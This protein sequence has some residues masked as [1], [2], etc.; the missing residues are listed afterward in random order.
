[1]RSLV[2][3]KRQNR[4]PICVVEQGYPFLKIHYA[5]VYFAEIDADKLESR[6]LFMNG[7]K[8][9]M[10]EDWESLDWLFF[11]FAEAASCRNCCT[12]VRGY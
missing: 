12:L 6:S 1:M 3:K 7:V 2:L 9:D 8:L 10:A 5:L 11:F 4:E